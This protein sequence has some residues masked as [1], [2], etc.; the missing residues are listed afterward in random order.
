MEI[1]DEQ[2]RDC[3]MELQIVDNKDG[4]YKISYSPRNEGRCKVAIK[5]NGVHVHG[6]QF[7]V[8]VKP[9]HLNLFQLLENRVRRLESLMGLGELQ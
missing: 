6:S 3:A 8:L 7:I 5:V 9:F 2:G 4:L 1:I